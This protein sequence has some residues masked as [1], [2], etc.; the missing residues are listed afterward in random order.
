MHIPSP[1]IGAC[2]RQTPN[3]PIITGVRK[4]AVVITRAAA[5]KN[6]RCNAAS[7]SGSSYDGFVEHEV[8][9][10]ASTVILISFIYVKMRC[11]REKITDGIFFRRLPSNYFSLSYFL[12]NNIFFLVFS[13]FY[14][15]YSK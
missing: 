10:T 6:P 3:N 1:G 12:L 8:D 11:I 13:Y 7:Y 14:F 9:I 4:F 5:A 2:R 15:Y